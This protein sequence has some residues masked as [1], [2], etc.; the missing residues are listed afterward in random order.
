VREPVKK[1][2]L[3]AGIAQDDFKDTLRRRIL[4]ENRIDLFPDSVEHVAPC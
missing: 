4:A 2:G 1:N 3:K